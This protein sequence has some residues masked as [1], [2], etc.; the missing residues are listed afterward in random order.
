L[1]LKSGVSESSLKRFEVTGEI[2]L[3]SLVKISNVLNIKNWINSIFEEEH[4]SS[5]DAV[6]TSKN[7]LKKR[8][9]I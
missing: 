8:G 9:T 3:D 5:L 2:S 6:I 1:A 7:K 4:F